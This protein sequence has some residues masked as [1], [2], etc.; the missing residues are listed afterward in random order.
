MRFLG[1]LVCSVGFLSS[2][3][4]FYSDL[5]EKQSFREKREVPSKI[6]PTGRFSRKLAVFR[7]LKRFRPLPHIKEYCVCGP[8]I[9]I[10]IQQYRTISLRSV[11]W[12]PKFQLNDLVIVYLPTYAPS[13][14]MRR[15]ATPFDI[16]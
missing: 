6:N 9:T 2:F 5:I 12:S 8:L 16:S 10:V 4:I 11:C 1:I 3:D 14:L 15:F 13:T 7:A